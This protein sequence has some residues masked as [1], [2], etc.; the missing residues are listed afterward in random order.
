VRQFDQVHRTFQQNILLVNTVHFST[1]SLFSLHCKWSHLRARSRILHQENARERE[2]YMIKFLKIMKV[3]V[4]T[5]AYLIKNPAQNF[6]SMNLK[7]FEK[8]K[9][10][11]FVFVIIVSRGFGTHSALGLAKVCR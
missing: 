7:A 3:R 9:Q 5:I 8:D 1:L 10:F 2:K 11:Q 4:G 6:L